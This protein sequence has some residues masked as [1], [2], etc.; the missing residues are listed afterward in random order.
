MTT[1]AKLET[2]ET[3]RIE[4]VLRPDFPAVEAYRFNSASIRVRIID[5]RFRGKS[6]AER[7]EMVIHYLDSLP[8]ELRDDITILLLLTDD[9]KYQSMMNTEFENPRRSML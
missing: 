9:E 5:E 6:K 2:D 3:R 8:T 7:H 4:S 1:V